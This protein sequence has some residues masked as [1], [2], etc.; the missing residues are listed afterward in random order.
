MSSSTALATLPDHEDVSALGDDGIQVSGR[1][2]VALEAM[3]Y[4]GKTVAD[5]ATV[6][7]L[8]R[9][10]LFAMLRQP[11]YLEAYKGMLKVRRES[12]RA[13]NL[14]RL[15]EIRD[16]DSNMNAAVAATKVLEGLDAKAPAVTVNVNPGWVIDMSG[17]G[18]DAAPVATVDVTPNPNPPAKSGT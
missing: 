1:I 2:R 15:A 18:A 14:H 6:S 10:S 8:Q 11:K 12:E 17:F 13:R 9:S 7:G 4:D 16:Q 3:V 5:A